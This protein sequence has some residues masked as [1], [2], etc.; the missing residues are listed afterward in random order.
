MKNKRFFFNNITILNGFIIT[1]LITVFVSGL[2]VVIMF[3]RTYEEDMKDNAVTMSY[4]A[5]IQSENILDDYVNQIKGSVSCLVSKGYEDE[6]NYAQ[7]MIEARND[8][9]SISMYDEEGN[10]LNCF[11]GKEE[12]KKNTNNNLSHPDNFNNDEG[13]QLSKPHVATIFEGYYPWVVSVYS[14]TKDSAGNKITIVMDILFSET[15]N[16]IRGVSI[17]EHGYCYIMGQDGDLIYH[18]HQ[19]LV[20]TG[21]QMNIANHDEGIYVENE[22]IYTVSNLQ[23]VEWKIVGVCYVDEMINEKVKSVAFVIIVCEII[24]LLATLLLLYSLGGYIADPVKELIVSM[25]KFEENAENFEYKKISGMKEISMLS[26]SFGLMVERIQS[27]MRKVRNEEITL[28][29]TELKALQAQINPHFLYNTLDAIAWMCEDGNNEEAGDMVTALASLFRISISKGHELITIDKEIQHAMSYLKIEK[30]RYK[31]KF[32]YNFDIEESCLKYYCN[33]I[34]L[35][36]II[37]NAIYHG[38]NQ[39]V[40]EGIIN[41]RIYSE[42]EDIIFKVSDNGVGMTK[43]ECERIFDKS[44]NESTGIGVINVDERVKIYFG[45]QYGVE[46]YSEVD[47]GTTVTIRMPKIIQ[48][49]DYEK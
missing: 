14:I 20:N 44:K 42:G 30:L 7:T 40:D 3:V 13:V 16:S 34:T 1:S 47:E 35:Q 32:N 4:Q 22:V 12:L 46:I 43:E 48:E 24:V 41:I 28:R 17:G 11:T 37:E 38:V 49:D 27:L 25:R 36:P 15:V 39:M 10:M 31:N 33:K 19:Q 26:D 18:P 9:V 8:I 23:N 29:K 45:S 21:A 5:V 6:Q 2:I